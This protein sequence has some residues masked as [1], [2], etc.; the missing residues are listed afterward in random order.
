MSDDIVISTVILNW[1][2]S[3]LLR[4]TIESYLKTVDVPYQLII[5]DNGS[6]D[7]SREVIEEL[8]RKYG[9]KIDKVI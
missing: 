2:R 3:D 8:Q 5:V 7:D 1:N 4:V 9:N 6:T